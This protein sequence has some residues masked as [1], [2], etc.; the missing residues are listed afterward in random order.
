[1]E[2]ELKN[3]NK[4]YRKKV[5]LKD[6]NHLFK[7][8]VYGILGPNGAGKTTLLNI[9]ATAIS[10]SNGIISLDKKEISNISDTY[11]AMIGYLPQKMEFYNHF[12]G[13]DFLK[14]M[15]VLKGGK[16]KNPPQID[17]LLKRLHLFDVRNHRI[18]TYSGGMKQRL[19]IIQAFLGSPKLLLLDEPT[20]GLDLEERAEF[21]K[22][23]REVGKQTI[24][25]LSTHIVSDVEETAD[26]VL[27]MH[28][29][30]IIE[31]NSSE[32]Y[33]SLM[34]KSGLNG[35]EDYYLKLAG[36]ALYDTND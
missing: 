6:I 35:L 13:Y 34:E 15:Y 12:T 26:Y 23:I 21:K 9:I 30:R 19:G 11:H 2:L 33:E 3:I 31:K 25:I 5:V 8:K 17:E 16:E 4:A 32:Y 28:E 1:M 18:S 14:Y 27:F 29:G 24:V 7:E 20:V 10:P 36:R 22:M